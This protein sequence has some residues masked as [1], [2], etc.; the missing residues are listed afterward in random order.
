MKRSLRLIGLVLALAAAPALAKTQP[1]TQTPAR[2]LAERLKQAKTADPATQFQLGLDYRN[3][4]GVQRDPAQAYKWIRQ[5]AIG[6]LT[7]AQYTVGLMDA[8]G[9]GTPRKLSDAADWFRKASKQGHLKATILLADM[10]RDGTGTA[11]DL[12]Q[13]ARLY[14]IAAERNDM[15]SIIALAN[16]YLKGEGVPKSP[17]DAANW[18]RRGAWLGNEDARY[19]LALVLF[20]GDPATRP[21][22]KPSRNGLEAAFWLQTA[23]DQGYAPAQYSLGMAY[24]GGIAMPLDR[25]KAM[26]MINRAAD[27]TY[28]PALR[29]LSFFY[30]TGR[31][32]TKDP[33][34]ALMYLDLAEQ[35][36]DQ[37]TRLD[38]DELVRDIPVAQQLL[39]KKRAQEWLSGRGL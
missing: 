28:A 23:A 37:H 20:D 2:Q 13:A 3:G 6:N 17:N 38:R 36:G 10:S 35:F 1:A 30:K 7:E 22:H 33:L 26:E 32:T 4:I 25:Y 9:D 18:L 11:V 15:H 29:Q 19:R 31:F 21:G 12:I 5:A 27:Q 34:R 24:Y 8:A 14:R 39:A 16:A